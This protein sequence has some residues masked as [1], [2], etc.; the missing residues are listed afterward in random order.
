MLVYMQSTQ[1]IS[2]RNN[3]K[4]QSDPAPRLLHFVL[5][6]LQ[7]P[8]A[9]ELWS[10]GG[11]LLSLRSEGT[12]GRDPP[13]LSPGQPVPAEPTVGSCEQGAKRVWPW[14]G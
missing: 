8:R 3:G 6:D 4:K 12:H 13:H 9:P 14:P 1:I 10:R 7:G 11:G 5:W 2:E